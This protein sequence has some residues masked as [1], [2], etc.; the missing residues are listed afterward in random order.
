MPITLWSAP[1]QEGNPTPFV[2]ST[3]SVA[4]LDMSPGQYLI[5]AGTLDQGTRLRIVAWG[6]Y[7][8]ASSTTTTLQFGLYMNAPGTP[9]STTPAT[10]GLG[11]AITVF[12]VAGMP[13]MI[14]YFGTITAASV[15][16]NATTGQIVGQGRF[17]YNSGT[18]WTGAR[19]SAI[20]PQT[21]AL[22]TVQQTATGMNTANTQNILVGCTLGVTATGMTS[23]T[24]NELTCEIIG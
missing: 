8:S 14:E 10:L 20:V 23:I 7:S 21:L 22:Q 16:A 15:V 12:A 2:N 18:G 6:S 19:T 4:L 3:L 17:T 11:P 24:T 9:L 13:W 5:P 1:T